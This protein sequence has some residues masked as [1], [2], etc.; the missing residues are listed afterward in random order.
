MSFREFRNNISKHTKITLWAS[1]LVVVGLG[2]Y[3]AVCP[4][5]GEIHKSILEFSCILAGFPLMAIV[6]EAIHEGL[7]VK[8]TRGNTSIE[9]NDNKK[10]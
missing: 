4:P 6:C 8:Y 7:N 1:F 5:Q 2:I 10:E 9:V 3:S